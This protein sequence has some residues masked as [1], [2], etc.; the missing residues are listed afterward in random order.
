MVDGLCQARVG[1]GFAGGDFQEGVP[2][3]ELEVGAVEVEWCWGF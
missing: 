1:G 2:D 3:F